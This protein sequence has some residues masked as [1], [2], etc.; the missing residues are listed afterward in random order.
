[1]ITKL[2]TVMICASW[3]LGASAMAADA[4]AAPEKKAKKAKTTLRHVVAFKFKKEA[5][6]AKVDEVVHAF[7]KL[8]K[9]IPQIAKFAWGTNS[10]PEK[11]DKGFTHMFVLTFLSAKDRDDYLVHPKHKEFGTLVGPV[12]DDVFVLDF[13]AQK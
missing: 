11:L 2:L 6:P 8:K 10:S 4:S 12:L 13:V 7:S 1:M 9:S 3:L 5:P